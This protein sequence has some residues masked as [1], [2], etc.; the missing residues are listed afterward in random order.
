VG[1]EGIVIEVLTLVLIAIQERRGT[2]PGDHEALT[3]PRGAEF[4]AIEYSSVK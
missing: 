3:L 1:I 4:F 2:S